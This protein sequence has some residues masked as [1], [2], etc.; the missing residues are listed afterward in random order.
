M[1]RAGVRQSPKFHGVSIRI[2]E[3]LSQTSSALSTRC[4]VTGLYKSAKKPHAAMWGK[5]RGAF[6]RGATGG[7]NTRLL[8]AVAKPVDAGYHATCNQEATSRVLPIYRCGQCSPERLN[9]N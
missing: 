7:S 4:R 1:L 9:G 8:Y 5:A 3:A 6:A 2:V